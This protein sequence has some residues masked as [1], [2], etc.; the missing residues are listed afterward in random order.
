MLPRGATVSECQVLVPFAAQKK[1][2]L[3][4]APAAAMLT[5]LPSVV[6]DGAE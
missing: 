4:P 1:R 3:L 2:S 5:S 6:I